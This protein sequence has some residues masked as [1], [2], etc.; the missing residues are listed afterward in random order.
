MLRRIIIKNT[1]LNSEMALPVTPEKFQISH[2]IK[3]ETINIHTVG[4]VNIA[5]YPTL[6]TIKIDCMFP[7]RAYP[8]CN[9]TNMISPYD[10]VKIFLNYCDYH[11]LLR[12]VVSG[13]PINIPV[14]MES[15]DYGE[16]DGSNDVYATLTFREKRILTAV[17]SGTTT[18]SGN[19][20]RS[21]SAGA[22]QS[23]TSSCKVVKGDTLS[24]ICRKYYGDSSLYAK[25]AKYNGIKNPNL[26][27]IG[28]IIKLP[29]AA[30]L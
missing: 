20:S 1:E 16:R 21:Y 11:P 15:I 10:Y 23:K 22:T 19:L 17:Q 30:Q 9:F 14:I 7:A 3:V 4:D 25:L 28:Q 18:K 8:F 26:I 5:G 2:G 24:A 27:R 13:T 12:F 6:A 29:P